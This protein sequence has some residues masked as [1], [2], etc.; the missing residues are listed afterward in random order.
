MV[1][2]SPNT[3]S[4]ETKSVQ[5]SRKELHEELM[6]L[7]ED[8]IARWD[9]MNTIFEDKAA[10]YEARQVWEE[11]VPLTIVKYRVEGTTIEQFRGFYNDPVSV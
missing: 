4:N 1:D 3:V 7:A 6:Q 11:N 5:K 8:F 10:N 2:A 9:T